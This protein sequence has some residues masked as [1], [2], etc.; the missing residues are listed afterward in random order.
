MDDVILNILYYVNYHDVYQFC[1]TNKHY[2]FLLDKV[3]VYKKQKSLFPR[4]HKCKYYV[5][6][7]ELVCLELVHYEMNSMIE[8]LEKCIEKIELL[9]LDLVYGDIVELKPSAFDQP[10]QLIY[11]GETFEH[12]DYDEYF[13]PKIPLK[14]LTMANLVP[15]DYWEHSQIKDYIG[16]NMPIVPDIYNHMYIIDG[17]WKS[18]FVYNYYQ[19]NVRFVYVTFDDGIEYFNISSDHPIIVDGHDFFIPYNYNTFMAVFC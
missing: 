5:I 10:H 15:I 4:I 19:Y 3:V 1:S 7:E 11:N 18:Y 9:F 12:L 16:F 8:Q 2:Y 6:P 13:F 17:Y 14:Y